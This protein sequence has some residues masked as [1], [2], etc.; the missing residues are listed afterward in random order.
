MSEATE[1][2]SVTIYEECH[3][4]LLESKWGGHYVRL[5]KKTGEKKRWIKFSMGVWQ[6]LSECLEEL[7]AIMAEAHSP[8]TAAQVLKLKD[9]FWVDVHSFQGKL[10]VGLVQKTNGER[11]MENKMNFSFER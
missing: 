5:T 10:Y 6:K 2:F 4:D 11:E 8:V 9:N 7:S 1:Y 3:F